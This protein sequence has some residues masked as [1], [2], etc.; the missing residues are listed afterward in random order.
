[1]SQ[2]NLFSDRL[3]VLGAR[4]SEHTTMLA[5][6]FRNKSKRERATEKIPRGST[7]EVVST[8]NQ[9]NH[10]YRHRHSFRLLF[11]TVLTLIG[12]YVLA[13]SG[14]RTAG[15]SARTAVPHVAINTSSPSQST[16]QP[17]TLSGAG[18]RLPQTSTVPAFCAP[19]DV[20]CWLGQAAQWIAQN[21]F[22]VLQPLIDAINQSSLNFITQTPAAGTYQNAT[23]MQ[24]TTWS[25]SVVN[26][27]VAVFIIIAGYN[28]MIAR[29]IGA[30]HYE[31]MEFLPRLALAVLAANFSLFFIR[32]FI[33]L[34]NAL[35][36]DVISLFSLTILTNTI[37]G[38]FHGNLLGAGLLT[39]VLAVVLGV[40]DLLVAWQMLLRLA[41]LILLIVLAPMAFLCGA[42][43][44]TQGYLRLWIS[45]FAATV[46]IQFFQVS[47]LAI[48]G[49]LISYV[50]AA[51]L[52]NLGGSLLSI[53]TSS[54]VLYLVLR[55][56]G[57][58]RIWALRPVAE[59]GP[60][61]LHAAQGTVASAV[62]T[63]LRLMALL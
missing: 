62:G 26:A 30:D 7:A 47:A 58:L 56:P 13:G 27:A 60:A 52:F 21:I 10:L 57:M 5:F 37:V 22:N 50:T 2:G 4:K 3:C 15:I 43:H 42:L 16:Q 25:I 33:D 1:M 46:F 39:F 11:L 20:N 55:I 54:A 8:S 51:N 6:S 53:I 38:I 12:F 49:T 17:S 31:L 45:T 40:M 18:E 29:Q 36:L 32:L 28:I 9:I 48:G 24:F 59:A 63:G 34:E 23:V 14:I 61:A 41:L 44:Q 19:F 35:N